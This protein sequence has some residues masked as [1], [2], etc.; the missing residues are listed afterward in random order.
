MKNE[1][2]KLASILF[3]DIQGYTALMQD[4]EEYGFK[5]VE[6]FNQEINAL[7][8]SHNGEVIQFYGDGVLALF[9][10][11]MDALSCAIQLQLKFRIAP[12]VPV[13]IGLNNGEVLLR[14]GNAFGDSINLASRIESIGVPGSI[15]FSENIYEQIQNKS[16]FQTQFVGE[17]KFKNIKNKTGVYGITNEDLPVPDKSEVT[18]KLEVKK[19]LSTWKIVLAGLLFI[20]AAVFVTTQ[21]V[22]QNVI[23][24][25]PLHQPWIGNWNQSLEGD[26]ER[27]IDGMIQFIDTLGVIQGISRNEY[28]SNL[29]PT[30]NKLF[31]IIL[32][33]DG[34]TLQG[35]W[36]STQ[37]N[38]YNGRFSFQLAEDQRSFNGYY[39][40]DG[41]DGRFFWNGYK[42]E[43]EN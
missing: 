17:F 24:E 23:E 19:P 35:K 14:E 1:K 43:I 31:D 25:M 3:A 29:Q 16:V 21:F 30:F 34:Q 22:Q 26:S 18:G 27:T 10:S 7:V 2:R 36:Q 12:E 6:K 11:T 33:E 8:P 39:S 9:D 40:M 15:L 41:S 42:E 37:W 4:D 38:Q 28:G 32:S 20:I 5:I 13:R